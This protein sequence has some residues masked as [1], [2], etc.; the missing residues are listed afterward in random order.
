MSN[1]D[2]QG[3]EELAASIFQQ[4][5]PHAEIK[6]GKKNKIRGIIS[7]ADRQIDVSIRGNINGQEILIVIDTKNKRP[8]E[9][10]KNRA[11]VNTV[12]AFASLVADVQATKGILICHTGFTKTAK[13]YARN[14]GIELLSLH[15][16]QSRDWNLEIKF[17]IVWIEEIPTAEATIGFTVEQTIQGVATLRTYERSKEY[18]ISSD[19]G[20]TSVFIWST[21]EEAWN[22][23][24]LN[25]TPNTEHIIDLEIDNPPLYIEA[26]TEQGIK[27]FR[28]K[29]LAIKYTIERKYALGYVVPDECQAIIDHLHGGFTV[30]HFAIGK[31]P[32]R[33]KGD[34]MPI[35]N[36]ETLVIKTNSAFIVCDRL[37]IVVD[38]ESISSYISKID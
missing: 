31:A 24:E 3:Y 32:E 4:L 18:R 13:N 25:R 8:T 10:E 26:N 30:A 34:W 6:W 36:D 37:Q 7:G 16:A 20:A 9:D 15:D 19:L 22:R 33:P 12:G 17:P 27:W 23:G 5:H 11:D 29:N 38:R 14:L 21:F 1:N 2:W 35:K 28:L